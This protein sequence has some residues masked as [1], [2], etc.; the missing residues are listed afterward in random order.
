MGF[1]DKYL[2]EKHEDAAKDF[3]KGDVKDGKDQDDRIGAIH[4]MLTELLRRVPDPSVKQ[5]KE[6]VS[7]GEH[8]AEKELD[9]DKKEEKQDDKKE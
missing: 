6:A 7:E 2:T 1:L 9:T 8:Y 5:E 4:D 3:E